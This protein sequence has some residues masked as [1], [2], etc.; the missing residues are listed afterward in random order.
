MGHRQKDMLAAFHISDT[1]ADTRCGRPW[2]PHS[3]LPARL[4][5]PAATNCWYA[6]LNPGAVLT[7]PSLS[8]QPSRSP[9]TLSGLSTPLANLSASSSTASTRSGVT[10]SQPGRLDTASSPASSLMT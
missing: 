1:A 7:T 4:V 3:G 10:S 8:L 6:C 9:D 2:P 5:H